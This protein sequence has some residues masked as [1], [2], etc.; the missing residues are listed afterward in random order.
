MLTLW[1]VVTAVTVGGGLPVIGGLWSFERWRSRKRNQSGECAACGS[2]WHSA[3]VGERHLIH[4]RLV[5]EPCAV[6]AKRRMPWHVALLGLGTA[7]A[8]GGLLASGK[9]ALLVMLP[10]ATTVAM[11]VGAVHVM[12]LANQKAQYRIATGEFPD[13][14]ALPAGE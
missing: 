3:S 8:T 5:C 7:V 12:K 9:A 14:K 13:L 2:A 4:G 1:G 11:T 10:I 6:A